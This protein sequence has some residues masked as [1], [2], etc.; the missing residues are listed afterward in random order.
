MGTDGNRREDRAVVD[1]AGVELVE[2]RHVE[3]GTDQH[4]QTHLTKIVPFLLVVALLG[5]FGGGAGVDVR[6]EVGP[7]VGERAERELELLD[8]PL[9]ELAF[10]G[11]DV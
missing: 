1:I 10:G 8:E 11:R 7:V 3:V 5:E 6:E 9:R 2:Q 4:P